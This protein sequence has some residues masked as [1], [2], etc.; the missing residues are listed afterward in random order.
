[1]KRTGHPGVRPLECTAEI[2][3]STRSDYERVAHVIPEIEWAAY[4]PYIHA[5]QSI[6]RERNA[7]ILAHDYQTP[8]RL[9]D[10]VKEKGIHHLVGIDHHKPGEHLPETMK[11]YN[12]MGT[13]EVAIIDQDGAIRMQRF[14][15]FDTNRAEQLIR[16]L[17]ASG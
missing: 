10:F 15:G 2:L 4:A 8:E 16:H 5:I 12:T 7:V 6:K 1:M 14:G 9:R 17:L 3:A 13:P 11:R